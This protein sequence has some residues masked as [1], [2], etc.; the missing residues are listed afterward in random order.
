VATGDY[1]INVATGT[2]QRQTNP[3]LAAGLIAAGFKGPYASIA[4]AKAAI[5][6]KDAAGDITSAAQSAAKDALGSGFHLVFGNTTGL[7]TRTLK[8]IFG[9]V[10]VIAGIM[11]LTGAHD[12]LEQLIPVAGKVL[13]A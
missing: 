8:I 6:G 3:I 1:Y 9:G 5:G 7:L 13:A 10:L 11:R 4:A 12:R 2:V